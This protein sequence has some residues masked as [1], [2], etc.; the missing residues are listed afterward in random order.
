MRR[1]GIIGGC[2]LLTLLASIGLALVKVPAGAASKDASLTA[3]VVSQTWPSLDPVLNTQ[4]GISVNQTNAIYGGLFQRGTKSQLIP[5]LA[6][7]YAF[8]NGDRTLTITI[9]RGVTFQDGTPFTAQAVAENIQR[10]LNPANACGCLTDWSVVTSVSATGP[11]TVA[12]QLSRPDAAL[13]QAFIAEAPNWIASPTA[14]ASE[15][16]KFGQSPIGAGPYQVVSNT[17]SSK[18]ELKRFAHFWQKGHPRIASVTFLATNSDEAAYAAMASGQ[19]QLAIGISTPSILTQSKGQFNVH[20]TP[21]SFS[22][23][24]NFKTLTP[25]FNNLTARKA[26]AYATNAKQLLAVASPG[27]GQTT[28]EA[29]GPGALYY[30]AHPG[31]YIHYN[32]AKA[33]ALVRQLGGLSVIVGYG[34]NIQTYVTGAEALANQWE[35]AGIKVTLYASNPV[36][37]SEGKGPNT[38]ASFAATGGVDPDTGSGGLP[39]RYGTGG[40]FTCC[41]DP[42]VDSL[43]RQ[44]QAT[45]NTTQRQQLFNHLFKY[46]NQ[47]VLTIPLFTQPTAVVAS[48]QVAN[49][50]VGANFTP[51]KDLIQWNEIRMTAGS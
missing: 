5:D 16:S 25:P 3:V 31:G 45:V 51:G 42:T 40:K 49:L 8:S 33:R 37:A 35:A 7:S 47:Q 18:L 11:H 23:Q 26:V 46:L 43:I 27:Y 15:G 12:L 34:A 2:V 9:R 44:S 19:A 32:L 1:I 13:P 36:L 20:L 39:V 48:K 21:S 28:E 24:V 6:T 50:L 29:S 41:S 4:A 38:G 17:P 14:L 30:N 22:Y 10:A